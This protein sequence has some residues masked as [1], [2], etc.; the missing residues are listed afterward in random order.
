M[1]PMNHDTQDTL[2]KRVFARIREERLT[3]R[4]YWNFALENYFFWGLGACAVLLGA[5]AFSAMIFEVTNVDWRL[6][7][8][9]HANLFS[10]LLDAAPFLWVGVL[11][12]FLLLGYGNVRRTNHGYRYSLMTIALGAILMSM[13]LG[14]ALYT[15]GLGSRVEDFVG[16]HL[17]FHNS[18]LS[19]KHAWWLAPQRG[20]LGGEVMS[21]APDA[22]F[23]I[24]RDF[25]GTPWRIDANDLRTPDLVTVVRGGTVRVVGLPLPETTNALATS[26]VF[27][28]CFVLPWE[29]HGDFRHMSPPA[30]FTVSSLITEK[31]LLT[32]SSSGT[33]EGIHP[34]QQLRSI[35]RTGF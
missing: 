11:T 20:L 2:A 5:F 26:S 16:N 14:S 23:F 19:K 6:A 29:L 13:T 30:P 12:L 32:A 34:F 33:C 25:N 3:P 18:I 17:P 24:L 27:H 15:V 4:P 7:G 1:T 21:V 22:T 31:S 28:A 10:F 8:V 35:E 9:T